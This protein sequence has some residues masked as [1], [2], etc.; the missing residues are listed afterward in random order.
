M[1]NRSLRI[2]YAMKQ[3]GKPWEKAIIEFR[4]KETGDPGHIATQLEL[5]D[6]I[7]N[8]FI[9]YISTCD[10]PENV[11]RD[12]LHQVNNNGSM[13][14]AHHMAIVL[15]LQQVRDQDMSTGNF[16]YVNGFRSLM[17]EET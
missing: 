10:H 1:T 17:E 3:S 12:L 4:A 9:D 15:R 16:Y 2:I 7:N 8:V 13:G 6:V 14:M 5:Y 11:V